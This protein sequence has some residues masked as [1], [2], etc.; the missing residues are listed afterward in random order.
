MAS[1]WPTLPRPADPWRRCV[2]LAGPRRVRTRAP[3]GRHDR[4]ADEL[5][6]APSR[7]FD[8]L[9]ERLR[10]TLGDLTGRGR[11]SEADVDAAMREIRLSLL[12]ADVNF[13]VVRD[14]VARVRERAI[15]AE[16]LESLTAGQQVVAIVH[17]E[18]IALLVGRRP[19]LPPP[20]QPGGGHG[21]R[22]PGLGQD[23]E[24]GQA[25]PARR[26]ARSPP[27]ARR[28]R[29]VSAERGRSARDPRS[30]PRDPGPPGARRDERRRHRPRR[31]R[32]RPADRPR[33]RHRR[34]RRTADH[35]RGA[36]GRDRRGLRGDPT[37]S[38]PS[39]SSTR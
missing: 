15:G 17:E 11:I 35:R 12:E 7:M 14:F 23:D 19:D 34:H 16:I 10:K 29:P 25:G 28:R 37:R 8:T 3:P 38:R 31:D 24:H 22:S 18:L 20:G 27:A 2:T 33:R 5:H 4:R 30:E 21:G 36:D 6:G 13:K 39:S 1:R 32:G 9:S 26:E